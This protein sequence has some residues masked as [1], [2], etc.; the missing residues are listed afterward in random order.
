MRFA[1]I[2]REKRSFPV[3]ALCRMLEVSRSGFHAYVKR[4]ISARAR[5]DQVLTQKIK[6]T[7]AR[8]RGVY[9]SPRIH[10]DLRAHGEPVGRHR[11]A[12]L[13]RVNGVCAK[14]KR[15]FKATTDSKHGDPIAPNL[16][17]RAF[18]VATPNRVWVT[19]VTAMLTLTGWAY[20][21]AML[22]LCS[23]RVVGW[24]VAE[25]NDT[26]L[27]LEALRAAIRLRRP[28]AGAIHHSDRGSPY[29]AADYRAELAHHG[30]VA[31]M[32]RKGD[33]WDNAVA[34][35]FFATLKTELDGP[36]HLVDLAHARTVLHDYIENFY[37]PE[38]RHSHLDYLSPIEHE[39]RCANREVRT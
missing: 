35:S 29:A 15:R 11:V 18:D 27:A 14:K 39:L 38:R 32:S 31:S 19:D 16:L 24:A 12:R 3:A 4:E 8:S 20:L 26:G 13:M 33:C 10:A 2:V 1:L 30:L 25:S 22:D 7:H 17:A 5:A 28:P 23:R 36:G 6:A 9:G 34:E 37:N 21:A